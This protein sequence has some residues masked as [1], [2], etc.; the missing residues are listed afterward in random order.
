MSIRV[1]DNYLN[2]QDF[3]DLK[4]LKLNKI[5]DTSIR[6]Y[7]NK[8]SNEKVITNSCIHIDFLKRLHDNYHKKAIQLLGELNSNK[9]K[10]YDHTGK[11][12][13][14]D[15]KSDVKENAK[16]IANKIGKSILEQ[17]GESEINKLDKIDDFDYTP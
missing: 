16:L 3:E 11:I 8:I 4:N 10:L 9:V 6:V 5:D 1:I 2:Q 12:I 17:V 15:T 14:Q 13:Y 7:H